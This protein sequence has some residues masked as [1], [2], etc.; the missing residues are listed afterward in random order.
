[1]G[2]EWVNRD[3]WV[4]DTAYAL[5]LIADNVNL[6]FS[7]YL[8]K[9]VGLNHLKDGTSNPSLSRDTFGAQIFPLPPIDEQRGI[10]ATLGALDDKIESNRRLLQLI[11][12][13][14]RAHFARLLQRDDVT[15]LPFDNVA[16]RLAV[17]HKHSGK[18]VSGRGTFV[19]LDQSEAG[20]LGFHSGPPEFVASPA[21]PICLFGDHTCSWRLG[22]GSFDV[23]PNVIPVSTIP[24]SE[25]HPTW[26]YFGLLGAQQFQEYRRHWMELKI[27]DI[28][29]ISATIQREFVGL[30]TPMLALVSQ[31][32]AEN[33]VLADIR[34]ALLPELLSGRIR[35]PEA[36]E[37]LDEAIA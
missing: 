11:S 24:S 5:S 3:F 33:Q 16:K 23:G 19:V 12:H 8:I 10:A 9:Y 27:H 20:V 36:A 4:I 29:W 15:W 22:I 37:S 31:L 26:L 28:P 25:V 21:E 7:Y 35:V 30:A 32:E 1:L 2:V 34:D 13:L 18:T 17:T 14:L 6:K